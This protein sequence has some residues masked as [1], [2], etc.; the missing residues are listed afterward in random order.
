MIRNYRRYSLVLFALLTCSPLFACAD[1][2]TE[3]ADTAALADTVAAILNDPA[4]PE[5]ERN[6]LAAKATIEANAASSSVTTT[7]SGLQ[8]RMN[9][10]GEG[11]MPVSGQTVT[12]SYQGKLLDTRVFDESES[13]TLEVD[14]FVPGF[15]EA[16]MLLRVGGSMTAY[17]PSDLAYG[18]T[19]VPSAGIGPNAMLVFEI[20]LL[21]IS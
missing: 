18:E 6:L 2:D 21:E 15:A 1:S 19:G 13:L 17:I 3:S 14:R 10:E 7:E 5:A 12:I 11:P 8:Y 9:V 16:L 4:L 20:T